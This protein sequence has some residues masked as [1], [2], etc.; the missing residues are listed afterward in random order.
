MKKIEKKLMDM[1]R[2][3]EDRGECSCAEA[4]RTSCANDLIILVQSICEHDWKVG[5]DELH[6][7][8]RK[9]EICGKREDAA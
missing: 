9:C 5:Q 4:A 1:A 2:E 6:T 7:L 8:H 3:W